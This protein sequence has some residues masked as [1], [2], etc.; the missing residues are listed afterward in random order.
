MT[1]TFS[2]ARNVIL[3]FARVAEKKMLMMSQFV[4]YVD[5]AVNLQT[6]NRKDTVNFADNANRSEDG[7]AIYLNVITTIVKIV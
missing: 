5:S 7:T 4:R 1:K 3:T 2:V 6:I